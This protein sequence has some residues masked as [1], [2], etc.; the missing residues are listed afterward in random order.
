MQSI[1][2]ITRAMDFAARRHS[3]HRRKGVQAEPYVN[4]VVEVAWLLADATAG[5]DPALVAAG[6]LY[7]TIE[8]TGTTLEEL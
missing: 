3:H 1:L 7:D 4:H 6:L 5:Q 2:L 8:D